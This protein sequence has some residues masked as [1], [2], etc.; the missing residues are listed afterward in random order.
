MVHAAA[1]PNAFV[2]RILLPAEVCPLG[3]SK[4][5]VIQTDSRKFIR[6]GTTNKTQY[7]SCA[8]WPVQ[9][10]VRLVLPMPNAFLVRRVEY[11]RAPV[12][13][14]SEGCVAMYGSRC[15]KG[16][17]GSQTSRKLSG[18]HSTATNAVEDCQEVISVRERIIVLER[19][20]RIGCLGPPCVTPWVLFLP[21]G[22]TSSHKSL[23]EEPESRKDI[24]L[25]QTEV[26]ASIA[27]DKLWL[28][29]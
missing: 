14:L 25:V 5:G 17:S 29:P 21:P 4:G 13:I 7:H 2:F 23:S 24:L 27:P 10:V 8:T 26:S 11:V 18:C 19:P 28:A 15:P 1:D 16:G 22:R 9:S 3:V 20:T 6:S 12:V